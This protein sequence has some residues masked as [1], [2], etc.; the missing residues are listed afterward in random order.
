MATPHTPTPAVV[1]AHAS[2]EKRQGVRS[3]DAASIADM[4]LRAP[5]LVRRAAIKTLDNVDLAHVLTE[6]ERETGSMYG[7][8]H[9]TPSGFI[10]DVLGESIW[11]KQREIVDAIPF[12]KRVACPAG[13]GVGKTWI[14]GRRVAWAGAVSP[15]RRTTRRPCRASTARRNC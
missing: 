11:S 8:W 7:L 15:P 5:V 10:E 13:F 12:H 3:S 14:A 9:D 6:V 1:A 2:Q 4:L